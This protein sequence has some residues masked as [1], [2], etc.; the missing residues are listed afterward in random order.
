MTWYAPLLRCTYII[1]VFNRDLSMVGA[2]DTIAIPKMH[3]VWE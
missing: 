1:F 3:H 2:L